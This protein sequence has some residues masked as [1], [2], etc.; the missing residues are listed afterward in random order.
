MEIKRDI[1]LIRLIDRINNGMIKVVTGVRRC[2]K[3]YLLFKLFY[4]YLK[5]L[6]EETYIRDIKERY[7][8]RLEDTINII[9]SSIGGLINPSKIANTFES[10]KNVQISRAT[11]K[12]YLDY[13]C[14]AFIIEKS[15]RYDVKGRKYIDTPFQMLFCRLWLAKRK[16]QF[17]SNRIHASNGKCNI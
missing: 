7:R 2:G 9:S 5:S 15:L 12:T 8:I 17:P 13:L 14:D 16:A 3:S 11:V 6:F 1:Y 10:V 4:A